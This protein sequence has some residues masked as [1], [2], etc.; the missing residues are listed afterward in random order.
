[1]FYLS[2]ID[3]YHGLSNRGVQVRAAYN[4]GLAKKPY[5]KLKNSELE[6]YN[7]KTERALRRG[8]AV[9]VAD[10]YNQQYWVS[11]VD[12]AQQGLQNSNRCVGAVSLVPQE[13]ELKRDSI[14]RNSIPPPGDLLPFLHQT[15][16]QVEN[17]LAINITT[18][19]EPH[20]WKFYDA[21]EVTEQK[22]YCV[23]L[24]MPQEVVRLSLI[25]I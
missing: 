21:A 23:P 24:K 7:D 10:N 3:D 22:I 18:D 8:L 20:D 14:A 2:L 4:T 17:S 25:H 13:I 1:M 9:G 15:L 19:T 6:D 11:R 16:R 5:N 12:A